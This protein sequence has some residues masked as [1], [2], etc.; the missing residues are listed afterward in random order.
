[1]NSA[2]EKRL[3]LHICCAP[4]AVYVHELLS[5]SYDVTCLFYNPNIQPP[6]EH[7]FRKRELERIAVI[8]QWKVLYGGYDPMRWNDAVKGLEKEP[9]RGRRCSVC[10]RHRLEKTFAA[11]LAHHFD[12]VAATL[13]I[14]P[15]KNTKQINQEGECLARET[16]IPFLKENFKKQDGYKKAQKLSSELGIRQQNYCGCLFSRADRERRLLSRR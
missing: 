11:A 2:S 12:V 5:A 7:E 16:G 10:F 6:S 4:C 14:S 15:Y 9:E 1:M 13:S 3:L 8:K